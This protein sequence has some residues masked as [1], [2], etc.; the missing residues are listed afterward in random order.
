MNYIIFVP[1]GVGTGDE[2]LEK[3]VVCRFRR[4]KRQRNFKI[5]IQSLNPREFS[6]AQN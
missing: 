3:K 4:E 5:M 2:A 1:F 6:F